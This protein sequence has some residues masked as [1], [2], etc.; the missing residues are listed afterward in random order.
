MVTLPTLV[1]TLPLLVLPALAAPVPQKGERWPRPDE[2]IE[3]GPLT[4][5]VY[6]SRCAHRFHLVD[7]LSQWDNACHGQYRR[8]MPLSEADEEV[9]RRYAEM[10]GKKSWGQGLEQTFYTPLEVDDAIQ[11]GLK[12]GRLDRAQAAIVRETLEH[13][14]PRADELLEGQR[15]VL[16]H[17]FERIDRGAFE[18]AARQLAHFTGVK[19]LTVPAFPIASPEGGGGGMDGGRL[20]WEIVDPDVDASVLLHE[21]THGFFLQRQEL[22]SALAEATPGLSTTVLGEGFAYATAPGMYPF[23]DGDLLGHE[24]AHDRCGSDRWDGRGD[25]GMQRMF[26]LALRPLLADAFAQ[27]SKLEDF[28]PRA[29][30]A[31]LAVNEVMM[32][33]ELRPPTLFMAGR[34]RD[35]VRERLRD[36]KYSLS[37]FRF[38][39]AAGQ[40]FADAR[41]RAQPGDLLVILVS[42]EDPE[43][44]PSAHLD[45]LP[46]TPEELS[47]RLR[48]GKT[49]EE[50]GL[51]GPLRVVLLAGPTDEA[52]EELA[53]GSRLLQP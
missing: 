25:Y 32:A 31:F 23:R 13:F 46:L 42:G 43:S 17:A 39:L 33:T 36:S 30:D 52:V 50:Q 45:L 18:Q 27:G 1:S 48:A 40:S 10:R 6:V 3:C 28:L 16:A 4:I 41:Q 9:L 20:R 26:G 7:Q 34:G 5:E 49:V 2:R 51:S 35:L 22:L 8:N 29:R 21:L 38:N 11:A 24:V 53:R 15:E 47:R 19:S 12:A 14:A 44:V 37:M